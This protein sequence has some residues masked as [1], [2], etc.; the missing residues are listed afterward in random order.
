MATTKHPVDTTFTYEEKKRSIAYFHIAGFTHYEG[1]EVFS[2]LKVGTPLRLVR[3]K[4]N[5]HDGD[6]V[7]IFYKDY[8]LG[9]IPASKN[10][11]YADFLDMGYDDIFEI[12]VQSCDPHQHPEQQIGVQ[13]SILKN[14][15]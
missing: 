3:E 6:A 10:E 11:M 13:V 7:M 14:K 4:D 2:K 5:M 15:R 8:K 1:C 12:R 9:Y